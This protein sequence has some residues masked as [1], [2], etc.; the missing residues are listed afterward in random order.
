MLRLLCRLDRLLASEDDRDHRIVNK[1]GDDTAH[2]GPYIYE[3]K[4]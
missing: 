3:M 2:R 4:R 1:G